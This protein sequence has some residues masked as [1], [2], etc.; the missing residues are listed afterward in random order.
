M[1]LHPEGILSLA[2]GVGGWG[3]GWNICCIK[4]R[5]FGSKGSQNVVFLI[6][7]LFLYKSI[8]NQVKNLK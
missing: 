6:F 1:D 2:K 5:D 7:S 8:L 4:R 3:R